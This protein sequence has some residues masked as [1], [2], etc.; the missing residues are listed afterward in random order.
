MATTANAPCFI[1]RLCIIRLLGKNNME[2]NK[3]A[4]VLLSEICH[5]FFLNKQCQNTLKSMVW[6]FF[7]FL[8]SS[9]RVVYKFV[10]WLEELFT[11]SSHSCLVLIGPGGAVSESRNVWCQCSWNESELWSKPWAFNIKLIFKCHAEGK[12]YDFSSHHTVCPV[13]I[14]ICINDTT[15]SYQWSRIICI[16]CPKTWVYPAVQNISWCWGLASDFSYLQFLMLLDWL[17]AFSRVKIFFRPAP[18]AIFPNIVCLLF[19]LF[20]KEMWM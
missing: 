17:G 10:S 5:S 14:Y 13:F 12:L 4:M 20:T 8:K 6:N 3:S 7:S 16:D 1:S 19:I 2:N 15:S 11:Y 9:R 18:Q